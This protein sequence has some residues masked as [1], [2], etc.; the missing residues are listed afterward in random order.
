MLRCLLN[1]LFFVCIRLLLI[2]YF[3]LFYFRHN[4][5][6]TNDFALQYTSW[7]ASR[8][9]F[10]C[11][12]CYQKIKTIHNNLCKFFRLENVVFWLFFFI[13][14]L[15]QYPTQFSLHFHFV[16]II[17]FFLNTI[18][19]YHLIVFWY[20]FCFFLHFFLLLFASILKLN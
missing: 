2:L 4:I 14:I 6:C 11:C 15:I 19:I 13:K 10:F 17:F 1:F 12:C 8:L 5:I 7:I 18:L 16:C 3:S 20:F 9:S